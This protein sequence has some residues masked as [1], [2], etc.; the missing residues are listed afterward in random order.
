MHVFMRGSLGFLDHSSV[1]LP[2]SFSF[3]QLSKKIRENPTRG[4]IVDEPAMRERAQKMLDLCSNGQQPFGFP[5]AVERPAPMAPVLI[6]GYKRAMVALWA[7]RPSMEIYLC[8]PRRRQRSSRADAQ[9]PLDLMLLI[10]A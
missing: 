8:I 1:Q 4:P 9:K 5:V 3:G 7:G 10:R 2:P 6:D